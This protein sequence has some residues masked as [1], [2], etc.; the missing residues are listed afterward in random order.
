MTDNPVN[1]IVP[2]VQRIQDPG[3]SETHFPFPFPVLNEADLR[4]AL[5]DS[6]IEP[7]AY[8]LEGVGAANGG[9]VIFATAPSVGSRITIWREM[10]PRRTTE[11]APG[12]AL[13]ANVLNDELDRSIMLLQQ[14][15]ARVSESLHQRP[16]DVGPELLLPGA[17]ERSGRTLSFDASGRPTP[18]SEAPPKVPASQT[19]RFAGGFGTGTEPTNRP[20]GTPLAAGDLGF[21]SDARALSIFDGTGWRNTF[22]ILARYL[23]ANGTR[24]LQGPLDLGG[25]GIGHALSLNGRDPVAEGA[26]LDTRAE[27]GDKAARN[28]S[29]LNAWE[30]ARVAGLSRRALVNTYLDVFSNET[31]VDSSASSNFAYNAGGDYY[32]VQKSAGG[33]ALQHSKAGTNAMRNFNTTY[34]HVGV[35]FTAAA[36]RT[37]IGA[38]LDIDSVNT[39]GDVSVTLYEHGNPSA[40]ATA[41]AITISVSGE[42]E[43]TFSSPVT[44]TSGGDYVL[45]FVLTTGNFTL[46]TVPDPG[47]EVTASHV[48]A[49]TLVNEVQDGGVDGGEDLRCGYVYEISGDL[50]LVSNAISA[51]SVPTSIRA[52][53]DVEKID[54]ATPNIDFTMELSRDGGTTWSIAPMGAVTGGAGDRDI[55]ATDV[56]VAAQPAGTVVKWRFKTA[57]GKEIRL[58]RI[59]LQ[60]DVPLTVS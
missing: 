47:T 60:A 1:D 20:D 11:F 28:L 13:R 16:Q 14:A 33:A 27:A 52:L 9:T 40:I 31:G 45:E 44:L 12:A 35:R 17:A 59:A 53:A 32:A 51:V 26:A 43:W 18:H 2:R 50:T 38:K 42:A 6:P 25:N 3:A 30:I 58:H 4:V 5:D 8:R 10:T 36:A 46:S 57:N 22:P 29:L 24:A 23:A 21:D 39:P 56:D 41:P 7:P 19:A 55:Y 37:A 48:R 49:G 15:Q 34:D 54:S